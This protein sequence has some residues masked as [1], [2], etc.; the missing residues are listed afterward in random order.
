MTKTEKEKCEQLVEEAINK[1]LESK[2]EYKKYSSCRK[3]GN[4]ID[5]HLALRKAD[6]HYGFAEGIYYSLVVL[7][8]ESKKMRQLTELI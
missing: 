8:Y 7:R 3:E 1:C 5:A 6:Q 4:L 2:E